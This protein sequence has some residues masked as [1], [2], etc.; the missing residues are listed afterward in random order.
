LCRGKAKKK[1]TG[2]VTYKSSQNIYVKF[3]GTEGISAGD[4]LFIKKNNLFE[5]AVKNSIHIFLFS[6]GGAFK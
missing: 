6:S 3:T 4:T 5:P 1:N 2:T